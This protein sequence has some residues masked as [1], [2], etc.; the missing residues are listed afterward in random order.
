[1]LLPKPIKAGTTVTVKMDLEE[2]IGAF[3]EET[4]THI[5]LNKPVTFVGPPNMF[6][7]FVITTETFDIEIPKTKVVCGP[8]TTQEE[9]A[10]L[11]VQATTDIQIVT[12]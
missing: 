6:Q 10:K 3:V 7:P 8:L 1:M 5:K 4:E 9:I 11:Y 12:D 2:V